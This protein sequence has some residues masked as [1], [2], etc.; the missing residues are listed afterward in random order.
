MDLIESRESR[1]PIAQVLL[2]SIFCPTGW[3][4]STGWSGVR[5]LGRSNRTK[6]RQGLVTALFSSNFEAELPGRSAAETGPATC[7][8]L[9]RNTASIMTA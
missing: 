8:T 3:T 2:N 6:Y 4:G 9:W 5:A 1:G 7:Y